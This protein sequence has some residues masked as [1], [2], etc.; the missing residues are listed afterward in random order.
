[1]L[2]SFLLVARQ[3]GVLFALMAVG[4]ACRKV[5]LLTEEAVKG[6][7]DLL[8]LVVTP[9]LIVHVFR[10]PFDQAALSA[11]GWSFAA[12]VAIHLAGIAIA[13]ICFRGQMRGDLRCVLRFATVFSNGG[14][15]AIPLE[16]ALLGA[17]GAFYGCVYVAVFNLACWSWGLVQFAGGLRDM[18]LR[19]LFVNPG[20]VGIAVGLPLFL[21]SV[22]LPA[23]IGDPVKYIADLNTP[24][25]M[26]VIGHYLAG[27]KLGRVLK[28]FP[29]QLAAAL[30]LV[31]IPVL[32]VLAISLFKPANG[33]TAV[34]VATAASA[35]AAGLTAMFAA[36]YKRD[37]ETAVGLVTWTTLL[38]ILT[39]PPVVGFALWRFMGT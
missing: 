31:V 27:A 5:R 17:D 8:M 38:S 34:A 12:A 14:F 9:C 35:P 16:Y 10:R 20:T 13:S 28:S 6:C 33:V 21:F 19:V 30:R 2:D 22:D 29:V 1:M 18:K 7:V 26:I 37:V 24:L 4:F 39:M 23:P 32:A 36:K 15:M 11:L 3:V 25:A